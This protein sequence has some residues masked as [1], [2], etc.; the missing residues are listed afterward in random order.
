MLLGNFSVFLLTLLDVVTWVEADAGL[1]C[2]KLEGTECYSGVVSAI[3][4]EETK[5]FKI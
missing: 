2:G 1:I 4:E 5:I 3:K